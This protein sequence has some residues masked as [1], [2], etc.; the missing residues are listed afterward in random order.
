MDA[1]IPQLTQ[2]GSFTFFSEEFG[3]AFHSYQGAKTEAFQKFSDAIELHKTAEQST[4]KLLDV[5]YGLGYNTAA[6]IEVIHKVNPN[7][8][9]EVYALERDATVPIGATHPQLLEY[10]SPEVQTILKQLAHNHEC[11]Q[12]DIKAK[13]LIGDARQTIQHLSD[14]QADAIFFDPFSPR[15]CPQLWTIEF[16]QLVARALAL[17][18]KLATYSR[19]ASVRTALIAAGLKIGTIPLG[20]LHLPH[21]WSQGTIAA[22]TAETLHPLSQMEQEHLNTRAAVPYRDRT[23]QDS[24]EAILERHAKEQQSN[25]SESTSSWRRRWNI[26]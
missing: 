22:W 19:S 20:E 4:V 23:L 13:L 25:Q 6:A 2:D 1:W 7:C 16:F 9:I 12:D 18:G 8:I 11:I 3:E 24:A 15:K 17:T 10:W 21:E 14:F 5:C 26:R